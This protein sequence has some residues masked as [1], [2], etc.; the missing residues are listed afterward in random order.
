MATFST[1]PRRAAILARVRPALAHLASVGCPAVLVG[2]SFVTTKRDPKDIDLVWAAVPGVDFDALHDVFKGEAGVIVMKTIFAA[3]IFPSFLIEGATG[4]PFS[5]FFQQSRDG[6][7]IGVV[8]IDL[9]TMD[10]DS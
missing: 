2:G 7:V 9:T 8:E 10:E 4:L 6:R 5:E 1:T 3:D